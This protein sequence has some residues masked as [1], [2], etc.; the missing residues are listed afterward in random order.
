MRDDQERLL[1]VLDA[2]A[3]VERR[4]G[5]N[6]QRFMEDELLQVW[7]V[8]HIQ[9]IGEACARLSPEIR[10]RH[11]EVPWT[12]VI[13]MRNILVHHY[14]GV[15]LQQIWATVQGDLPALALQVRGV[16]AADFPGQDSPT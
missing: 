9:I 14:F 4:V 11:E 1:D 15:D 8:H 5:D 2:V 13:A 12:D 16:I 7:A 6:R 10:K 3:R